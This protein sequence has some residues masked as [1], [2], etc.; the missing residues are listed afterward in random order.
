MVTFD[1]GLSAV[2]AMVMTAGALDYPTACT[3]V[4]ALHEAGYVR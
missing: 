2:I 1:D 3:I 4:R